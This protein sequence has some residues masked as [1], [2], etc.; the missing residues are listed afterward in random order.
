MSCTDSYH[1]VSATKRIKDFQILSFACKRSNK[2]RDEGRAYYSCGVLYDN[3]G[4][5]TKAINE[6]QKFLSV[7]K[8]I[9]DTHGI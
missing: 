5:H 2:L 1:R 3:L 8:K 4:Q 9:G 7:C 6:Y